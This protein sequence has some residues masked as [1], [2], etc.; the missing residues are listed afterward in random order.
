MRLELVTVGTEL[1]LGFTH[2]TNAADIAQALAAIGATVERRATVGDDHGQIRDVVSQALART[3]LVIVTGGLGPTRDD[4]TKRAVAELFG[5]PLE[6]DEAYLR[7]LQER[8]AR[9]GR[10]PMPPSNRT[11]AE[12]PRGAAVL[13]NPRGTAPGLWLEG[14]PGVAILLPGVPHEMRGLLAEQVV[15]RISARIAGAGGGVR[16][17]LSRTLRTSGIGESALA[18]LLT[19]A[20]RRLPPITLAYLPQLAGVDLRLT[21]WS[22]PEPEAVA[23]LDR[24]AEALR[25]VLG[26]HVYGQGDTA[27]AAVVLDLLRARSYRLALAESC[28]GGLVG[29]TITAVPGASATFLGGIVSYADG[30]KIRDLG[31]DAALLERHGA[32]SEEVALAMA[33]GAAQRFGVEAAAA[34]TGIAG[35]GGGSPEKP[36][37]TVCLAARVGERRRAVRRWLPGDRPFVRERSVHA[38]LDLLRRLLLEERE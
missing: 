34:V 38:V 1:L 37:G 35:P 27:L 8:F 36:V 18:D 22:L 17:T 15:P 29:A 19:E 16:V 25:P 5:A 2:D 20:E 24:A 28:T 10:G 13:P 7:A 32:V 11:Q 23:A 33:D 12:V 9:F 6:L 4:V 31:V 14:P 21:A 30:S 3:R 26:R